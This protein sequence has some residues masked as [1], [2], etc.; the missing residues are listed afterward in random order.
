MAGPRQAN[1]IDLAVQPGL[2]MQTTVRLALGRYTNGDNVRWYRGLPQ[3]MGG[4]REIALVDTNGNRAFYKGHARSYKQWDSL[5]GNNWIAFGTE[6]K[7]YLINNGVLYDI[8]PI[9]AS[10]TVGNGFTTTAGSLI[11]NVLDPN[12]GAQPGDFVTYSA[13]TPVGNA[14]FNGEFQ[15][16]AVIDANNYQIVLP[17]PASTNATGGGAALAQYQWPIGLTSDGT[18]T[19]YGTGTYGTG[20]YGTPRTASTYGGYARIWSVD[21]WGEDLLASPNGEALFWWQR[22]AGPDSRAIIRPT[23]PANIER[24]LVGPDDRHVLALGT[25]LLSADASSV[26]GQQDKMFMRWCEGD[27][28]DV[29]VET[30]SN[31]AG[32]KRLDTGSRLV[33]ACKTRTAILIFSDEGLYTVALTGGQDVYQV[34]PLGGAFKIISPGASADV[35]GVVYWMGQNSFYFFNGTINDLPCDVA[36]Y[37]FGSAGTPNMNRQMASK[38]TCQ[39]NQ[40]FTEVTWNF[41]SVNSDENDSRVTYNWAMQVWYVSSIHREVASDVNVFYGSPIG[42][43]D[44]GVFM[45]ETGFDIDVEAP[46]LN[47]LQT[48]EGEFAMTMRHDVP[49][50][51]TLWANASGSMLM[52]LHTLYPDLKE[53]SNVS[54]GN[55]TLTVQVQGRE[56]SGDPLVYGNRLTITPTTDQ[57]D[58][59]F[60]QRRVSIYTENYNFGDFWRM[61]DYRG[62]ATPAGRRS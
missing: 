62:L 43:N 24:M 31:D 48:W 55:P 59:Q 37:V 25:N 52:L 3:K 22:Q 35:D 46:L 14:N 17:F 39:V 58:P 41:P 4:F 28:F 2:F 5:D 16:L 6:L 33:T 7:L 26:T 8:T 27:N 60:C 50:N 49:Q 53:L 61:G 56:Y 11:V 44:G 51:Q 9:R 10:T 47:F 12:N 40:A 57:V 19:G 42:I 29:W 15:V 32:S 45:D 21:N 20:T 38:I 23:A 13:S 30:Q 34:N 1:P 54:G 18:L 36:D